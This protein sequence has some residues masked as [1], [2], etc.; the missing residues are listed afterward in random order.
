[1]PMET[2]VW[3]IRETTPPSLALLRSQ[4][5]NFW[6]IP[7]I[8]LGVKG[9]TNHR[10]GYHRSFAWIK[11]SPFCTNSTYSVSETP[12]N[13]TPGDVNW[14]AALDIVLDSARLHA[15]NRRLDSAMR[16][17]RLEKV[18]QWFGT[19]DGNTVVGYNNVTNRPQSSDS[20][21]LFHTHL[22]FDRL[23]VGEGHADLFLI[24]TGEPM[25]TEELIRQAHA[26]LLQ[27]LAADTSTE[28]Q[29]R[30]MI[31]GGVQ[32]PANGKGLLTKVMEAIA[33][34]QIPAPAPVDVAAL[35][36]A[37]KPMIT[38]TVREELNKTKLMG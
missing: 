1:M 31:Q 26:F 16:A 17:G 5:Q 20:S 9:D 14:L 37:L 34:L 6:G 38:E 19:F 23:R 15:M 4:L 13:R 7:S 24:L 32:S 2:E 12:G 21:H 18:T 25:T 11:N 3:W 30:D 27:I 36:E 29:V 10:N 28:R 35:A 8:N 33:E 22:S